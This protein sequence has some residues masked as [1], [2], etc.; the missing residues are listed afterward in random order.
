MVP[1][2]LP[3]GGPLNGRRWAGQ[4]LLKV[5]IE[6]ASGSEI[7]LLAVNPSIVTEV[8]NLLR[9]W[10][11]SPSLR[12]QD[13]LTTHLV[14]EC[15]GLFVPDPSIGLWSL[16]R[17][18]FSTPTS[19]S[20]VGQIHTL[21]TVGA[22]TRLEELTS[23]NIFNWDSLICSSTA[24][25]SVVEDI[26]SQ[27]EERLASRARVSVHALREHRPQLPVIPLP[28]PL[29]NIQANMPSKHE[30]RKALGIENESEVLV[31]L[32]RITL[33]TKADPAPIYRS[34][35]RIARSRGSIITLIEVG[36]DD[37]DSQAKSFDCLRAE[38]SSIRFIR[39]GSSSP[40]TEFQKYQALSAADI[41][42]SLVDNLQETFGQSVVELLAAGLPVVC[43]NWDGY[44]DLVS[45]GIHGFLVPSRWA[46][47]ACDASI[48]IG[49][50]HRV[51]AISYGEAAG[52][53]AQLVQLDLEAFEVAIT[54]LLNYPVLR[55]AMGKQASIWALNNFDINV[56]AQQY[57]DLSIELNSRRR[58]A[59]REWSQHQRPPL[60]VDPVTCFSSF[61]S[62]VSACTIADNCTPRQISDNLKLHRQQ[63][64]NMLEQA[65]PV[66]KHAALVQ[67]LETK[68][69]LRSFRE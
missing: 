49:W 16:W 12:C 45:D 13:L 5:W 8:E 42:I 15:G 7:P 53:L 28:M 26:L 29:E 67:C 2:L 52:A 19:F 65:L 48:P 55:H 17:D 10:G 46:S 56:V 32:G 3:G 23:E 62:D 33:Y 66:H 6:L 27:R 36:P 54:T 22:I 68:H 1:E 24:G 61:P 31:W 30:S 47:V 21:C 20:L 63:L 11:V 69:G 50:Q 43:S 57:Q 34:L 60:S 59:S 51:G 40:V 35:D 41:G 9:S 18:A 64:W 44:R 37:G 4:Q 14:E 58:F 39:L 25:K 38:C